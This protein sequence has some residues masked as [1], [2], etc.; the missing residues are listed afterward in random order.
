MK[1][2]FIKQYEHTWRVF[3]RIV[4]DFDNDAW[5]HTGRGAITP[6]R[7]AFHILKGV[8]ESDKVVP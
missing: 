6:A 1:T 3:E 7:L 5:L 8:V 4:K 2:E